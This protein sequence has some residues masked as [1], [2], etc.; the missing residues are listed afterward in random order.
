MS[1]VQPVIVIPVVFELNSIAFIF[2]ALHLVL[3]KASRSTIGEDAVRT[4]VQCLEFPQMVRMI[5]LAENRCLPGRP[6][7]ARESFLFLEGLDEMS[8][9]PGKLLY[10]MRTAVNMRF[11]FLEPQTPLA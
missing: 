10:L 5:A 3:S 9:Q 8:C 4:S 1:I 11:V 2:V 6:D 7:L